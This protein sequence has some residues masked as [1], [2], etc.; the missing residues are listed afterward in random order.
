MFHYLS[1]FLSSYNFYTL[2]K[3]IIVD[4]A[5]IILLSYLLRKSYLVEMFM[6]IKLITNRCAREYKRK[7]TRF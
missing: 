3:I 4:F 6:I 2:M 1:Y 5:R 7:T